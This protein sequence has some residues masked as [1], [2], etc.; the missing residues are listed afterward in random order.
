MERVIKIRVGEIESLAKLNESEI[1]RLIWDALPIRGSVKLW[2]DEIYSL[3]PVK[4][5][6]SNPQNIVEKG[7][8]GYWE[9]GH[10]FCI[11]FGPTPISSG[12]EIKPASAVEVVGK[13][14]GNSD[15]FKKVKAGEI[16]ILERG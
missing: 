11:F 6:L 5:K 16:I 1:A 9:D 8:L 3:I 14:C 13:L 10:C 4:A 7:D 15:E 12:D 2:G